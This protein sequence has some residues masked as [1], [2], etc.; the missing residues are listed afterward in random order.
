MELD[1]PH[2]MRTIHPRVTYFPSPYSPPDVPDWLAVGMPDEILRPARRASIL[3]FLLG[4]LALACALIVFLFSMVPM[5]QL[6]PDERQQL[7]EIVAPTGLDIKTY[8]HLFAGSAAV[9]GLILVV[10]GLFVRGG[11][12]LPIIAAFIVTALMLMFLTVS[13]MIDA[14]RMAPLAM[15][16]PIGLGILLVLLEIQLISANRNVGFARNMAMQYQTQLWQGLQQ[17][18]PPSVND[19][20]SAPLPPPPVQQQDQS[21]PEPK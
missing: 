18:P 16:P 19:Y 10:L 21:P 2:C 15:V 13:I 17:L 6:P 3:L 20:H 9:V 8:F 5:D 11:K 1:T 4:G 7:Q 12:R 14:S